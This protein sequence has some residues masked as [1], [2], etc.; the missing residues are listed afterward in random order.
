MLEKG[1]T[2][3]FRAFGISGGSGSGKTT[4]AKEIKEQLGDDSFILSQDH[5]YR[6]QSHKFDKDGGEVNFDHP[7]SLELDLLS[8]H[9]KEL[10]KGNKIHCPVYDFA[11]HKRTS[12]EII[13]NPCKNLIVEGTLIY[14]NES[15]CDSLGIKI[16]LDI[17]DQLRLSRR[18]KRD[19][20]TRGRT[21]E[22]ILE[23]WEKQVLPMHKKYVL[24]SKQMA[25]HIFTNNADAKKQIK[26]IF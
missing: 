10:L 1:C 7:D 6:D 5:Y 21:K 17:E 11:T 9:I 22:G 25:T 26:E 2:G 3:P 14:T 16:F 19:T 20:E 12:E 15:I 4:L 24:R 8:L 18:I 23:Q 13:I